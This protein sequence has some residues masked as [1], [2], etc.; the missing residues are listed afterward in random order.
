MP[1]QRLCNMLRKRQEWWDQLCLRLV[2]SFGEELVSE[3]STKEWEG[4]H[5]EGK[6]ERHSSQEQWLV[7]GTD[8]GRA[9]PWL[10]PEHGVHGGGDGSWHW[11]A[12]QAQEFTPWHADCQ[13]KSDQIRLLFISLN[14]LLADCLPPSFYLITPNLNITVRLFGPEHC[15]VIALLRISAGFVFSNA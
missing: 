1:W 5:Q 7:P 4:T 14:S 9:G 10:G 12:H 6:R 15:F 8:L 2:E 3:L 13:Q 11:F